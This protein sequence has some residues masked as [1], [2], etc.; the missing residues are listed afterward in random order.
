MNQQ[1]TNVVNSDNTWIGQ[2]SSM[3]GYDN[4]LITDEQGYVK[5]FHFI[6]SCA[7]Y[8]AADLNKSREPEHYLTTSDLSMHIV[9]GRSFSFTVNSYVYHFTCLETNLPVHLA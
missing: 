5:A 7:E 1:Q 3:C 9:S 6:Y 8:V 4:H 2:K